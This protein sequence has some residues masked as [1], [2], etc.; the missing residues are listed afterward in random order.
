MTQVL[1]PS[2][3]AGAQVTVGGPPP[4]PGW[5]A[6][7]CRPVSLLQEGPRWETPSS[8][9]VLRPPLGWGTLGHPAVLWAQSTAHRA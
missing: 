1:V 9:P 2:K 3:G 8:I 7:Q 5:R 6:G 4:P